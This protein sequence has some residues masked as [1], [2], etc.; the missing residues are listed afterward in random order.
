MLDV[1]PTK[2]GLWKHHLY[3]CLICS[4]AA[5]TSKTT[6]QFVVDPHCGCNGG[7]CC[8]YCTICGSMCRQWTP[9]MSAT[10]S[11]HA[12][13]VIPVQRHWFAPDQRHV[14]TRNLSCA[15]S[16]SIW[17]CIRCNFPEQTCV[18]PCRSLVLWATRFSCLWLSTKLW[19]WEKRLRQQSSYCP[20]FQRY[21]AL[22]DCDL[23]VHGMH[24]HCLKLCLI[25]MNKSL[26]AVSAALVWSMV[27]HCCLSKMHT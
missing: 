14:L 13:A 25:F 22:P 15:S 19:S 1:W 12:S 16:R 26:S 18:S 6:L 2:P 3:L 5:V 8:Q 23:C 20:A 27:R 7:W 10:T 24:C 21:D 4:L 17:G 9:S 11:A